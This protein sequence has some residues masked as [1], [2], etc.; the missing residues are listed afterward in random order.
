MIAETFILLLLILI[1]FCRRKESTD[2]LPNLL[3]LLGIVEVSERI[4]LMGFLWFERIEHTPILFG[5]C[6]GFLMGSVVLSMIFTQLYVDPLVESSATLDKFVETYKCSFY[7]IYY[8]S[9]VF[10][11]NFVRLL[12]GGLFEAPAL[13]LAKALGAVPAF[14]LPLE[15]ICFYKVLLVNLPYLV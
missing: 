11:V 14:R 2:V 10:G 13:T 3:A 12:Y 6:G 9:F 4:M 5:L 7:T 8:L 15:K 1:S